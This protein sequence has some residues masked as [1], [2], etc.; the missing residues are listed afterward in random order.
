MNRTQPASPASSPRPRQPRVEIG[1]SGGNLRV[2]L[3][4]P[5]DGKR[6]PN[7]RKVLERA[8]RM[9]AAALEEE[10]RAAAEAAGQKGKAASA[11]RHDPPPGCG[12]WWLF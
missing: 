3:S 12:A 11:E 2:T 5:G 6:S 9:L 7:R 10:D 8:R 1:D 4:I